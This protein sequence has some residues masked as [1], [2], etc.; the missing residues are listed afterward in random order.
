VGVLAGGTAI[1]QL[2]A[3]LALPLVT[4]LYSPAD[5]N[6]LAVY[7][8]LLGLI[9]VVACLR[10]EIA[11]PLPE[12]DV[13]AA[14]L[15]ALA[16]CC[17]GAVSVLM[18]LVVW[19]WPIQIV[20][21]LDQPNLKPFLWTL[22]LGIGL[23]SAYSALQFWATRNKRFTA[24]A[25]TRMTQSLG[26]VVVKLGLGLWESFGAL[27]LLLGQV[28]ASGAG[29]FGLCSHTLRDDRPALTKISWLGMRKALIDY[30]RFP[31][32]SM[33]E[34][35][36]NNA[37]IQLPIIIIAAT[38]IGPDAGYLMLSTQAMAVPMSLI[39]GAVSQV[40]LSRAPDENRAGNL[41]PFTAQVIAG[42]AKM[43]VGPILFIGMTA[44]VLFSLVFGAA[45]QRAG[46]MVVW[47]TPW[48]IMQFLSS[49][50]SMTL[51]VTGNQQAALLLQISGLILRVGSV[52]FALNYSGGYVFEVYA[53][54]GF[55]FYFC[56][57]LLIFRFADIR[58]AY[59]FSHIRPIA[60]ILFAW[61]VA[62][63]VFPYA[64]LILSS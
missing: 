56:Y 50:V 20:S 8:A 57:I 63:I 5:F 1:A 21:L 23:T 52:I 16:L 14:N 48:F 26:G 28:I 4:R 45:W 12:S 32:F 17:S 53:I 35:F 54:S 22:P 6:V 18:A 9:G 30:Q 49:P 64:F 46:E 31:K 36:A 29:I 39:G 11:I 51:H 7:S 58:F 33:F 10:L 13:D 37:A 2:I 62:G 59:F 19:L 42:L 47:M 3:V 60:I 24:V 44:P 38:A 41:G 55:V 15:L 43:G 40:Y 27:G 61:C 34:S 25:K